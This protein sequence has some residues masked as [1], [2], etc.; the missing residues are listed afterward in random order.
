MILRRQIVAALGALVMAG[1][2]AT[3]NDKAS[4][5][6]QVSGE[7]EEVAV[8][9]QMADAFERATPGADVEIVSAARADHIAKLASSFTA[10][11]PPDVFLVNYREYAQFVARGGITSIRS[12]GETPAADYYPQALEAFTLD[13]ALQCLPQ[14]VS[15]LVV[16]YNKALFSAAGIAHPEDWTWAQ[17]VEVAKRLTSST[18]DGVAI[19]PTLVRLAPLV[20]GDGGEIVD[21]AQMPTRLTLG[22]AGALQA[23]DD[24]LELRRLGVT[25][26]RQDVAALDLPS[27]FASGAAAMLL[28]SRRETP[29]LRETRGLEWDVAPLPRRTQPS[30]ILH[31]DA[32][33]LSRRARAKPSAHA[34]AFVRFAGGVAG[35]RVTSRGGR[36]VPSVRTIAEGDFLDPLLAPAHSRVFVDA[37]P[38]LRRL[39]VLSTWPE[40][41]DATDQTLERLF[42]DGGD[43]TDAMADLDRR[44]RPLFERGRGTPAP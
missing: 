32:W 42:Y 41:E 23:L 11:S 29:G 27:R 39:P 2:C 3:A 44:T 12:T 9:R 15:S 35:Q 4:V 6:V 31:S 38:H 40:I 24:L 18:I 20:W 43:V 8:Y 28:S 19:E 34:A 36:V 5:R 7:P 1:G 30:G 10:G 14:N 37:I 21:S 17:F 25:P 16:Y 26:S 22:T 33:C 13:G